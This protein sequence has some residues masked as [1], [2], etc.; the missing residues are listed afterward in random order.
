MY[1]HILLPTD[2]SDLSLRA[3]DAGIAL[4]KRLGARVHGLN[5]VP[6]FAAINYLADVVMLPEA[7]YDEEAAGRAERYLA[8][9]R[10]RAREAGVPCETEYV[11]EAR[12]HQVI[13]DVAKRQ[14]CD[15]IV[16]GSHGRHGIDR[17]LLGSEAHRV[18]VG[19]DVPVLVCH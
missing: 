19:C 1:S 11:F 6:P 4:A 14:H 3:V 8:D 5:V 10:Q 13:V 9:V 15:L 7:A 18:I 17:W 16:M 2:G 12:P